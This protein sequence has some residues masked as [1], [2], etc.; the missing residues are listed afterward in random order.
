MADMAKPP[1]PHDELRD[2]RVTIR[3]TKRLREQLEEAAR[4]ERR[5]LSDWIVLKLEAAVEPTK[6][7]R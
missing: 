4:T 6:A 1:D 7:R 5:S 3:L 2:E